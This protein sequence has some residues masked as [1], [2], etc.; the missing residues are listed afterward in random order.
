MTYKEEANRQ[1]GNTL[2]KTVAGLLFLVSA[3]LAWQI[4]E[5]NRLLASAHADH[6]R[7]TQARD[8]RPLL[9]PPVGTLLP[10]IRVATGGETSSLR[11]V[12]G[13]RLAV[14]AVLKPSCP[15]CLEGIANWSDLASRLREG[16]HVLVAVSLAAKAETD[17]FVADQQPP[18]PV[19]SIESNAAARRLGVAAV[20]STL[21]VGPDLI[22]RGSWTGPLSDSIVAEIAGMAGMTKGNVEPPQGR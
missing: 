13:E 7:E 19:F 4:H 6:K 9:V 2:L 8:S 1:E 11:R 15:S 22:V 10:D 20:P 21:L 5:Q 17:G 18:W 14:I 16:S 12:I 3:F